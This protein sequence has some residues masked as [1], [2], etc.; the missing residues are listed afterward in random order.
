MK[1]FGYEI[2]GAVIANINSDANEKS[3]KDEINI[4][5]VDEK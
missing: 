5:G 1:C 3:V 2:V 4:A